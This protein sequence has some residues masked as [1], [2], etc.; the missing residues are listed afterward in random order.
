[1]IARPTKQHDAESTT[2]P[3]AGTTP[4]LTGAELRELCLALRGA[5]EAF[6]FRPGLSV[7]KVAG[8]MFALSALAEE[9]LRVSIKCD[10]ALGEQLRFTHPSISPGYHLNKRHW[11][12]ITIDGSLPT[13]LV[14]NLIEGSHELVTATTTRPRQARSRRRS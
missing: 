11:L 8:K 14:A 6:P 5:G 2:P 12:T 9:P 7:F 10:P 13:T 1:M 4:Q 3:P